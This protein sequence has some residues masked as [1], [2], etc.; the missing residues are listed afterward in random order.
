MSTSLKLV[1]L[2]IERGKHLDLVSAFLSRENPEVACIQEL[3]EQD[4]PMFEKI[5]GAPCIFVPLSNFPDDDAPSIIGSAIF[6]RLPVRSR[7]IEHYVG[8]PQH[9]P[10][11]MFDDK[12][13]MNRALIVCDIEKD[14]QLFRIGTTHFTWTPDGNPNDLQ[15]RDIQRLLPLLESAG[16]L[17][18]TGD[19]NAP[20]GQPGQGGEIWGMLAERYKDNVPLK[21]TTSLDGTFHRA[22]RLPYMVDGIFS[23]PEYQVS[24]VEMVCGLSDHCALVASVSKSD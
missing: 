8:D 15:K 1:S 17:V 10:D 7:T 5:L 13:T 14:G 21:Y 3:R 6:S 2:N 12:R 18:L 24:N 22:G 19:F 16:E 9:I 11:F 23:T 4:I 20:R